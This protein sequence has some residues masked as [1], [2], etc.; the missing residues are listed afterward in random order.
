MKENNTKKSL[1]IIFSIAFI[2]RF[3]CLIISL[4]M[5]GY[6]DLINKIILGPQNDPLTYNQLA[7]NLLNG[8]GFTY[9]EGLPPVSLRTPGYPV[10]IAVF[11]AIF[12]IKPLLILFIQII[13]DSLTA[14]IIFKTVFEISSKK[15]ALIASALYSFEP[16][17]LIYSLSMYSDTLFVF[18]IAIFSFNFIRFLKYGSTRYLVFSTFILGLS[19]IVKPTSVFVPLIVLFFLIFKNAR[20]FLIIKQFTVFLFVFGIIISPWLLRNY[21][22]FNK[23]FLS[24]AGD[25]NLLVLNIT[26]IKMKEI[27]KS[28]EETIFQLLAEADSLMRSDSVLPMFNINPKDYW[29]ELTLQYDFNKAEYW[30]KLAITYIKSY[31]FDFTKFY[32]LGII[33]SFLNLGSG[34]YSEYFNL[35]KSELRFNIKEQDNLIKL[36]VQF[37]QNKSLSEIIIG[38]SIFLYL[39]F[40]YVGLIIGIFNNKEIT[41]W[42]IRYFIIL[43]FIYFILI[44]GAGGLARF[45]LPSLP[46]YLIISSIGINN[47]VSKLLALHFYRKSRS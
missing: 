27:K 43:L 23:I 38:F 30:R 37:F 10:F 33:H 44:A 36:I 29:E 46:F 40:V 26:P 14:I 28:Q 3:L 31:P 5:N 7:I 47:F 2:V 32:L 34:V 21:T 19:A 45:K 18:L 41:D 9:K 4:V 15:I 17:A 35:N 25:Y 20:I 11:Y 22:T 42:K 1:I 24:T 12:G 8:Y 39:T 6:N 16:H 13:M